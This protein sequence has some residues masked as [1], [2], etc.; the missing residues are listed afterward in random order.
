MASARIQ[1]GQPYPLGATWNGRGVNFSL[2]SAHAEKV[3]LCLFDRGGAREVA[4]IPL[5]ENTDEIWHGYVPDAWPGTL[6]GY[7]VYGPYDP[8]RGHRFNPNKLL[9]DPY[10]KALQGNLHWSDAH[11]GYRVGSTRGDL[12]F[13]RRDNARGVPKCRVIDPAFTWGADRPLA[14]AWDETIIYELHM[15]GFTKLHPG[16]PE[17]LRGTAAGMSMRG[18]IEYIKS[19]GVTAVELLPIQAFLSDRHLVARGLANYWGY[20]TIAFF[21]PEPRYL[22]TGSPVE[23]KTM[24]SRFHEAGIEVILD[25]V[26][27]HTGEGNHLGPTLSFRGIDNASYY[28]LDPASPRHY[29]DF[30]GTGNTLNLS[31]PRVIQ[32]VMDCLRHWVVEMHVD[33][34]RF[35]LSATLGRDG[36]DFDASASLFDAIG[37]DPVLARAKL[38]A[39]P[40]DLGPG[41]YQLGNHGPGWAEWNDRFRDT[42]R[43]FWRGDDGQLPDFAARLAGSADIF[44]RRRRRPWAGVN[45]VTAHDGFTLRDLV[46]YAQKHNEA[47]GEENRDGHNE[48][49]SANYGVEGPTTDEEINQLRR[50]QRRNLLA[51]LLFS[52]GTPMLLAGDEFGRSQQGNN[53]AYCQ[54]NEVS[55]LDWEGID[56]EGRQS[57]DFVRRLTSLRRRYPILRCG[58]FLHGQ[59][60]IDGIKDISWIAPD[61]AEMVAE[62]WHDP[63]ARCVG[64]MLHDTSMRDGGGEEGAGPGDVLLLLFNAQDEAVTFKLPSV[65]DR[66]WR[67]LDDTSSYEPPRPQRHG[68][69]ETVQLWAR[70]V[71]LLRLETETD[72][73]RE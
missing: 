33:G 8:N 12:S 29:V 24:V 52:Q 21:A 45:Y 53:N 57:I 18:V 72:E 64:L 50:R 43:R 6:Y 70:S 31:H 44:D 26:F 28:R 27:N 9:I 60:E 13:D 65:K 36:S 11:F 2:F 59:E 25:I 73:R 22:S 17:G 23:F 39:E 67:W 71:A 15:R 62:H 19:L 49:Y 66:P 4:R 68:G 54:D 63:S 42:V 35:D 41:G 7:R 3:E 32:F 46:S 5:P 61:G 55:W 16:V 38:I 37:Q 34:F 51:T 48:N 58:R 40:W 47:N 69:G 1:P 14:R 56:A 20:N 10:T 30:T